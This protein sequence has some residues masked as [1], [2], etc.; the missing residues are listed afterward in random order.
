MARKNKKKNNKKIAKGVIMEQGIR[1][2]KSYDESSRM[3]GRIRHTSKQW[4]KST[5]AQRSGR[6]AEEWHAGTLNANAAKKGLRVRARTGAEMQKSTS[7]VD[8]SIHGSKGNV[9]AQVK[10]H[11][12]VKSTTKALGKKKYNGMQKVVAKEQSRGVQLR[13][14]ARSSKSHQDTAK[15]VTDRLR[16]EGAE[17]TPLSRKEALELSKNTETS[18][19]K[20]MEQELAHTVT[21]GAK[22]GAMFGGGVSAI[23]NVKDV[24]DG[25]KDLGEAIWDTGV[26][27]A[28]S[29]GKGAL[30]NA[31]G[32]VVREGLVRGGAHSL[33]RS[34]APVA[35]A[36]GGIEFGADVIRFM[37]G[38]IDGDEL[39]E[40]GAKTAVQTGTTLGGAEVG[41]AIG[42]A[43]C[44]GLGTIAGGI[45]GGVFGGI[46]GGSLFD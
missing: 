36:M 5:N 39:V 16:H 29:A 10:Y 3:A 45:I 8:I 26:D 25:N 30:A 35:I 21:A 27:T 12:S 34:S 38:Q 33:A 24:W 44:P 7:A 46:F 23:G 42:S 31:G 9:S 40:R 18:L 4:K 14:K 22:S 15:N 19:R 17:S 28:V 6:M 32:V 13:A 2:T 11:K 37:D 1:H 20:T 41:A 43:I